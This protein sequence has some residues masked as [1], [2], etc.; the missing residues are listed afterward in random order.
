MGSLF[1]SLLDFPKFIILT[2]RAK[3]LS[4]YR[5]EY[6]RVRGEEEHSDEDVLF[7]SPA[8]VSHLTIPLNRNGMGYLFISFRLP[9]IYFGPPI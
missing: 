2:K 4:R 3:Q 7:W 5:S 8:V 6:K 1:I 9:E